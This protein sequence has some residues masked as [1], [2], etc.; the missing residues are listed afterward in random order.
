MRV[1]E[2]LAGLWPAELTAGREFSRSLR[3]LGWSTDPPILA[4]AGYG[5]GILIA[6]TTGVVLWAIPLP[7]GP[8]AWLLPVAVGICGVYAVHATPKLL[9]TTRRTAA[10]GEAPTLVAYATLRMRISP[11]PE[12]A[13]AFAAQY[14]AGPLAGSLRAHVGGAVGS[15]RSG[16]T[17]FGEDWQPWFPSLARAVGM[18]DA[19]GRVPPGERD[20]VLDRALETVLEGT[21]SR[22]QDYAGSIHGPTTAL[23]AFG[24]LLPTALVALVP[25]ARAAGLAVTLPVVVL[26]YDLLLP[27]GLVAASAWLLAR[28]PVAFPPPPIDA[29][30]PDVTDRRA[31]ALAAGVLAGLVAA[32]AA[33]HLVA[34]WARPVTAAGTGPGVYLVLRYR[35]FGPVRTRIREAEASLPNALA[36]VGRRVSRGRA[37]EQAVRETAAD[38]DGEMGAVL[39]TGVRRQSRTTAGIERAL[40]GERGP[41]QSRPSPRLRGGL[42]LLALAAREG[43]SVG[44]AIQ[45]MATHLDDLRQV[46]R[47]ARA[48]LDRVVGTLRS[49]GAVFGPLVGG[50][51]VALAAYMDEAG[52]V[53]S[54]PV[55][56]AG[57]GAAVGLYVLALG[58]ILTALSVGLERGLDR[59]L[60]AVRVGSSLLAGTACFLAGYA[61][62]GAVT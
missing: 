59:H 32:L 3:F 7:L 52:L 49:T 47:D 9:A 27:A 42:A 50:A 37:V 25:A 36:L 57:L 56:V 40:L 61:V 33:G 18:V 28:R 58:V 14:G 15:G 8:T 20:R 39:E 19:A 54:G 62:T 43:R 5:L 13:A 30:H 1:I 55:D 17:D 35:S 26:V 44:H 24:V 38:L 45:S 48:D 46:E 4:R 22:M 60:V 34:D 16:L 6:L 11:S 31:T 10:L 51:T 2:A 41:L 29:N 23:Y 21:R 53:G 12:R